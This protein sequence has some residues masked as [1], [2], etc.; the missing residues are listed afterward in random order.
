MAS[1]A[2][3]LISQ[4]TQEISTGKLR[5]GDQLEEDGLAEKFGV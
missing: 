1:T 3:K 5:P 4:N 2:D